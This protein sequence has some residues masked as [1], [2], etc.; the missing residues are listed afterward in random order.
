MYAISTTLLP[1]PSFERVRIR[2]E[3]GLW[4]SA[5]ALVAI[6][7][8]VPWQ[9]E[10]ERAG[11]EQPAVEWAELLK[12]PPMEIGLRTLAAFAAASRVHH[13]HNRRRM[14]RLWRPTDRAMLL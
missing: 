1:S 9:V 8:L 13:T 3:A 5:M 6:F 2:T 10:E 4:L 14:A 12:P 7:A 11:Y